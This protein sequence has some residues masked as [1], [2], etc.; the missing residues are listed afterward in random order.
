ME[1]F[2]QQLPS[3]IHAHVMDKYD[4]DNHALAEEADRYLTL[5]GARISAVRAALSPAVNQP[6]PSSSVS[7]RRRRSGAMCFYHARY[8]D[9]AHKCENPCSWKP[10]N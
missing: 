7:G 4:L 6:G 1:M 5:T 2:V 8:G 3:E 10:G 9:R